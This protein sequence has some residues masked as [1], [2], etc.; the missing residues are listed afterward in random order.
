MKSPLTVLEVNNIVWMICDVEYL[1]Q[2]A[3]EQCFASGYKNVD[4]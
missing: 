1:W 3:L 2:Q 4:S